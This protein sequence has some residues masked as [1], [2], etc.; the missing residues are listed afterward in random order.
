MR[1]CIHMKFNSHLTEAIL[2]K[3]VLRFMGEVVMPNRQK[4]MVRCPTIGD[5]RGCDILGTKIW[6]SKAV[7]YNCLP[8]WEL[9][10]VDNGFLVSINPEL[11]KPLVI[12]AIKNNTI[13]QA[14][15]YSLRHIGG[16][17]DQFRSQFLILENDSRQ[18]YLGIEQVL[19]L[20]E[21]GIGAFPVNYGDG[22]ETLYAL[23]QA[24]QEGHRAV[25]LYC[26]THT[27]ISYIKPQLDLDPKYTQLLHQAIAIGV[28][29]IAYR[30]N[31]TLEQIDLTLQLPVLSSELVRDK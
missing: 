9:V 13:V 12:E 5:L 30:V 19:N 6:Y 20:V 1:L 14:S 17:F 18:L 22:I 8:T 25:L 24:C 29:I 27:G 28:E 31:I 3:R 21:S 10:E 23:I 16:Q 4:L 15:G 26:V 2:L 7:G 11:I